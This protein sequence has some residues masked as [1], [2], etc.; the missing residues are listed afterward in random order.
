VLSELFAQSATIDPK[1]LGGSGLIA[2]RFL[3]DN[4]KQGFFDLRNH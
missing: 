4:A 3:H 2:L 1:D